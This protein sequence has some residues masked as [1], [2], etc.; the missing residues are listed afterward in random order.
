V[1]AHQARALPQAVRRGAF[2]GAMR[3]KAHM[4][5]KTPTDMGQLRNSWRVGTVGGVSLYN[6]AP[7]AGILEQGARPH[8]VSDV[9]ML[10]LEAWA[11]RH[12]DVLAAFSDDGKGHLRTM[13]AAAR[14]A[15][16]A[17]A[18]KLRHQGQAPTYFTRSEMDSLTKYAKA[19]I[20]REIK[21]ELS[22]PPKGGKK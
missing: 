19:E 3:G 1:L 20:Q 5:K 13:E 16:H 15:A 7:H 22:L 18:W 21:K 11:M 4:P 2:A 8:P 6:D 9:G 10:A 12:P 14:A 17:V